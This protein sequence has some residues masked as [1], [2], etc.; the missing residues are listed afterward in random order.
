MKLYYECIDVIV[1]TL[2]LLTVKASSPL[3]ASLLSVPLN[4]KVINKF[5]GHPNTS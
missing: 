3:I 4:I 2:K 5:N 1:T